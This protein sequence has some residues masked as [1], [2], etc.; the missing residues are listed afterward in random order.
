[1][2]LS[3]R[4]YTVVKNGKTLKRKLSDAIDLKKDTWPSDKVQI[5]SLVGI[6]K[7]AE[8]EDI[9]EKKFEVQMKH[10]PIKVLVIIDLITEDGWIIDH[11]TAGRQYK[12]QWTQKVVDANLQLTLYAAVYRKLFGAERGREKGVRIDVLPRVAPADIQ[13][14]ESYRLDKEVLKVLD[15]AARIEKIVELGVYAVNLD[16]C[17]SC[18]FNSMCPKQPL[19]EKETLLKLT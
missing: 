7:L 13:V 9:V 5:I 6:K 14:F 8:K 16:N 15:T 18:E 3:K 1:V 17:K 4:T 10:F 2:D 12:K 11:K 19:I